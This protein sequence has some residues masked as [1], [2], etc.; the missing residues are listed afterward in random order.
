[1]AYYLPD[2]P[3]DNT[4]R[5]KG[6]NIFPVLSLDSYT[7]VVVVAGQYF[8]YFMI[9]SFFGWVLEGLYNLYSQGSFRKEGFLKGP[10]K[11]MYGF[12]PLLLLAVQMLEL[13]LPLFLGL[14]LI[15]PSAVEYASG[16]LL[17]TV[18]HKQWWDYSAMPYQLHGHIC[19]KFSLYWWVLATACI[20]LLQPLMELVYLLLEPIW[21]LGMPLII[22][23]FS[24][25]LL[26][27]CWSR[28]RTLRRLELGEG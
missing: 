23:L 5:E 12:A 9:Y 26:W 25:D 28:R 13:P 20:Y 21:V 17:K 24:A 27:T 6:I 1:M 2:V 18:F 22:M 15:I 8:F 4:R 14:T 10:F 19:L 16:W 7:A 3:D 11:P